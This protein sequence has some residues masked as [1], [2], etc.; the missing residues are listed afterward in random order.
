MLK[1]LGLIRRIRLKVL[2]KSENDIYDAKVISGK[3]WTDFCEDLKQ[4]GNAL[5]THG[6]PSD[7]F[8]Q[9]EGIRYLSRLTRAG[10]EAYLEY[11]D[12]RF[13]ELRR[14]VHETVKMGADNPDN[15]YLNAQLSDNLEY[16]VEGKRN[17][18]DYL[19]FHTQKGR[20]GGEGGMASLGRIGDHELKVDQDGR[21]KV[22]ITRQS[23]GVNWLKMEDGISMLIVRMTYANRA[24]EVP[25]VLSI[26]CL[27]A[28]E[29]PDPLSSEK[30][31]EGLGK[32]S[33]LV[34]G[35]PL[36]F[37]RWVNDF[38][39]HPNRLPLFD[40]QTSLRAG[41]DETIWYFHSY[42]KL[43][44]EEALVIDVLPPE[45]EAWNFQ[46]NNIWMESLDY[47]HFRV[48]INKHEA[49]QGKDGRIRV[50]VAH[51]DPG[52]PNWI[53][54]A[55][56]W[57]GTMCWRWYRLADGEDPLEPACRVVHFDTLDSI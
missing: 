11:G 10:L 25:A 42:W 48:C 15:Y 3:A 52:H 27:D 31:V 9:A 4:A 12:P 56:H 30:L 44:E 29:A 51:R 32:A 8:Q 39:K 46:L 49:V 41:G 47:R 40:P 37:N 43:K 57:E 14:M 19:S 33:M 38:R 16:V 45:C 17:S 22:W 36:L 26:R 28:P 20:Y 35:A 2:G 7:S 21:F 34:G 53:E 5:L 54:T 18:I 55:H 6:M 1:L 23:K 13:P 24:K 50:I